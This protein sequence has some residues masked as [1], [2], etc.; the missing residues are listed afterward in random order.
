MGF[1]KS[2]GRGADV[3]VQNYV[4]QRLMAQQRED[5][6]TQREEE[7]RRYEQGLVNQRLGLAVQMA[8]QSGDPDAIATATQAGV[9]GGLLPSTKGIAPPT[10]PMEV[11]E[12]DPRMVIPD[13]ETVIEAPDPY[14]GLD[15]TAQGLARGA[16]RNRIISDQ[17]RAFQLEQQ[18]AQRKEWER[19]ELE[20]QGWSVLGDNV[21]Y[22]NV[23]DGKGGMKAEFNVDGR[24]DHPVSID[25][26]TG[27]VT[28]K[29][30]APAVASPEV[31]AQIE[32]TRQAEIAG[33]VEVLQARESL[34]AAQFS[35][36]FL[37]RVSLTDQK[38]L[39]QQY[40]IV[41]KKMDDGNMSLDEAMRDLETSLWGNVHAKEFLET[42]KINLAQSNSRFKIDMSSAQQKELVDIRTSQLRAGEIIEM[43]EDPEIQKLVGP[44]GGRWAD[45]IAGLSGNKNLTPRQVEFLSKINRLRD[46]TQRR[47]SGAAL[48][49][50]E[51][52]FYRRLVGGVINTPESLRSSLTTLI[53]DANTD[54][55]AFYVQGL[56]GKG[57]K[58]TPEMV[59][60]LEDV[61]LYQSTYAPS[62]TY[63]LG[64][65][66]S[67][68][69][70]DV[71]EEN[72]LSP[73]EPTSTATSRII[74]RGLR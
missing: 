44:I 66:N 57:T 50:S 34:K 40:N 41:K 65:D 53:E 20:R 8:M 45:A 36:R 48:T 55:K 61:I 46:N 56:I 72:P 12:F 9:E 74:P 10:P 11:G 23:P 27:I 22:R 70:E 73:Q 25:E 24:V 29:F 60:D 1:M 6:L 67:S 39:S 30:G 59:K 33:K 62:Q 63:S 42:A 35:E 7:K 43:L 5:A 18:E 31:L 21:L 37:D 64:L 54:V 2:L 28:W 13:T 51:Q 32:K 26:R 47:E 71:E 38:A 49:E 58:V 69:E 52:E 14:G 15:P 4:R 17:D 19:K 3:G 68:L 16:A